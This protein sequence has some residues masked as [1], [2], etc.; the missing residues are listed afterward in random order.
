MTQDD[1][2]T[3]VSA[4]DID[5]SDR[6]FVE[7]RLK[8]AA[9]VSYMLRELRDRKA[10]PPVTAADRRTAIA[11]NK[12]LERLNADIASALD[13][14][15]FGRL[16][17]LVTDAPPSVSGRLG[18]KTTYIGRTYIP[19]HDVSSWTAPVARLWYTNDSQYP[20]PSGAVRVRVDLKRFLRIR[21]QRLVA[22]NDVYRRTLPSEDQGTQEHPSDAL[23]EVLSESGG[24]GRLSVIVET[25]EPRQYEA[26]ANTQDR[27]LIV[28]GAAGSGKSEIGLHRIAYLLS[29]FNDL[30][31][32]ERPTPETTLFIGP[33]QAFLEYAADLLPALGVERGVTQTTR[34]EWMRSLRSTNLRLKSKGRVWD[35]LLD[36][37]EM[38]RFSE[39]AESFKG[40]LDMAGLL[41]R[42]VRARLRRIQSHCKQRLSAPEGKRLDDG[43]VIGRGEIA[44]ALDATLAAE[45]S[46]PN[47]MRQAFID[48]IVA[49]AAAKRH[50][51]VRRQEQNSVEE[52]RRSTE[53]RR[54]ITAWADEAWPRL[55]FRREYAALLSN[56]D[57]LR[58]MAR[59]KL[60]EA[61]AEELRESARRGL[62][63]GFDDSDE[64][65]LTYLDHLLNGTITLKYRHIVIDEAQDISPIEFKLLSVASV[66]NWFTVMGDLVQRLT[67]YRGIQRWEEVSRI[68][69]RGRTTVQ[70][71]RLSYRSN[72]HITRFSN[73][74][75]RLYEKSLPAPIPY[76]REG[77]RPEYHRHATVEDMHEAVVNGLAGIR[78]MPGLTNAG[79]AILVRDQRKLSQ[80]QKFC[81]E[82]GTTEVVPFGQERYCAG[83][84]VLARISD[85]RGLEYDAVIVLGVNDAFA[86]TPFNQRLLY[87]A[88]NRAKHYLALHWS[89]KQ[90][91]ILAAISGK[92]ARSF[93]HRQRSPRPPKARR[94]QEPDARQAAEA[95]AAKAYAEA[96]TA[97]SKAGEAAEAYAEAEAAIIKAGQAEAVAE[98][99]RRTAAAA[100]AA[101]VAEIA[102]LAAEI[103]PRETDA[104]KMDEEVQSAEAEGSEGVA[105]DD[106]AG[107]V[108]TE[109]AYAAPREGAPPEQQPEPALEQL[110]SAAL[111]LIE[112]EPEERQPGPGPVL[113]L[114]RSPQTTEPPRPSGW[115][116]RALNRLRRRS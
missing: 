113:N 17:Y 115:L 48:W 57:A 8:L 85:A 108:I 74:V 94:L 10:Q 38:T 30:S 7:E 107:I 14:P 101:E 97:I 90:S 102:R 32:R 42:H 92:G 98:S 87:I 47:E 96:E 50:A 88:V 69:G 43:T 62:A 46:C 80:F 76:E 109:N 35:N 82:R 75:L 53:A 28:Q 3:E 73:R 16:D 77:H 114:P 40:S 83:G 106:E 110:V 18:P 24:E 78:A 54:E 99:A 71:A 29:P 105:E 19:D 103:E 11:V 58:R 79:I 39:R 49:S 116:T 70:H 52:L 9:V 26:I 61:D 65:A 84:T 72:K 59:G 2:L 51:S 66:N 37:G 33:S 36:H 93:D 55:D 15:Y 45:G 23:T 56:D 95:E 20:A 100:E 104:D 12:A 34:G 4:E 21:N 111:M 91:P 22:L 44:E 60:G 89:G 31:D 27:A 6:T 68:L 63:D 13:Q 41:E 1:A 5:A 81:R 64:G 86:N 67:P 112:D 25:I